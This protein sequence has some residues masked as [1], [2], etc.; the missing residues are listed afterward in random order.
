MAAT[1]VAG[2]ED[3]AFG[4]GERRVESG[5]GGEG[6][7]GGGG[8]VGGG[9]GMEPARFCVVISGLILAGK[10]PHDTHGLTRTY[11]RHF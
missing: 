4:G 10:L 8:G 5:G 11:R 6:G 7:G 1:V 2:E 9:R 3:I